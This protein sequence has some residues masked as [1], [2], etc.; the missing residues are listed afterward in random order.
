MDWDPFGRVV[1]RRRSSLTVPPPGA[2]VTVATL[3]FWSAV[4]KA[5]PGVGDVKTTVSPSPS[6]AVA[7]GG[8]EVTMLPSEPIKT[9]VVVVGRAVSL[10]ESSSDEESPPFDEES[11]PPDVGA[12][13]SEVGAA[14]VVGAAPSLLCCVGAGAVVPG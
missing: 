10:G 1:V 13:S 12:A 14:S 9:L 3:P 11:A 6:V 2:Y 5:P 7:S 8:T 4:V